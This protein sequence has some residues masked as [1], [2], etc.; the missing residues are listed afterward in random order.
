VQGLP[1]FQA[2]ELRRGGHPL[3]ANEP[4]PLSSVATLACGFCPAPD[5]VPRGNQAREERSGLHLIATLVLLRKGALSFATRKHDSVV[6]CPLHLFFLNPQQA[7][8]QACWAARRGH[9]LRS[10]SATIVR[11]LDIY[12]AERGNP[13]A[14]QAGDESA[15][16]WMAAWEVG[17]APCHVAL[18]MLK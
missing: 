18:L 10:W 2:D 16:P 15:V 1:D 11:C 9:Y 6:K 12:I 13:P 8:M 17:L 7:E 14:F 4:V 5:T 3:L